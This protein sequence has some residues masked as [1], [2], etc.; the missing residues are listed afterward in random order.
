MKM[1]KMFLAFICLCVSIVA[2]AQCYKVV[3]VERQTNTDIKFLQ[4]LETEDR[5][6]V[7]GTMTTSETCYSRIGRKT[8]IVK[9]GIRY[10][11]LNSVNLPLYDEAEP[12]K[13][14]LK[15]GE[16][17]NFVIEFEKFDISGSFDLLEKEGEDSPN[18]YNFY[19]IKVE[20]I[21]QKEMIDTKRFL[22]SPH[23]IWGSY[24]DNGTPYYYF[25]RE[26]VM[27]EYKNSWF[28]DDFLLEVRVVNNSDHGIMVDMDKI[29]ASAVDKKDRPMKVIRYTADS[30]DALVE[31]DRREAAYYNTGGN[32]TSRRNSVLKDESKKTD[33]IWTQIGLEALQDLN[34]QSQE[35]RIQEYLKSHPKKLA[36]ALRTTSLKAGESVSGYIPYKKIRKAKNITVKFTLDDY[37]HDIFYNIKK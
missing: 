17:A 19:G 37:T 3:S 15:N 24:V 32:D 22:D 1:K 2:N 21:D 33:N 25:L 4:V 27:L 10:K 36:N 26:G 14:Y 20:K 9:N 11:I 35:N 13:L 23:T 28:D 29:H 18:N 30:Y 34:N 8:A 31:Q 6:L 5:V 12:R 16:S 7:Y